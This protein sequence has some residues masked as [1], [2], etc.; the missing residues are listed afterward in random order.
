MKSRLQFNRM[1]W[2]YNRLRA[3]SRPVTAGQLAA[4]YE[5]SS[6]TIYRDLEALRQAGAIETSIIR[7][8]FS[9]RGFVLAKAP[10]CPWC[11]KSH[12]GTL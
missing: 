10:R 2:L 7:D 8:G 4:E 1:V 6:K 5:V 3:A 12:E 9:V 11:N